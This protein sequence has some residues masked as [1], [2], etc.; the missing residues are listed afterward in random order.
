MKRL[1]RIGIANMHAEWK[2]EMDR[3]PLSEQ[4]KIEDLFIE[5]MQF[6]FQI[7]NDHNDILN[8]YIF[9]TK[10]KTIQ[11]TISGL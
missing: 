11:E 7:K 1:C 10:M 4:Q 8:F 9:D 2:R 3:F 6:L 5:C